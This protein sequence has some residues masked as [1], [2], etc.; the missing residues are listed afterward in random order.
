MFKRTFFL[1]LCLFVSFGFDPLNAQG[2]VPVAIGSIPGTFSVDLSGNSTYSVPIKIPPGAAGTAPKISLVYDSGSLGGALGAGWSISGLSVITRGPKDVFTDG[3]SSGIKLD[4]GDAFYLDGQRLIPISVTG[5][6][7]GRKIEYRK[8]FD[9]QTRITQVG[10]D[11]GHCYFKVETKGGVI[12]LF[13]GER[14]SRVLLGNGSTL[15]LAESAVIDTA[16]SRIVTDATGNQTVEVGGNYIEFYYA[17]NGKGNYDIESIKYTGRGRLVGGQIKA[18]AGFEPFA[19]IDFKYEAVRAL[20][21]Y[22]AGSE[23]VRDVRLIE[24][25][26][27]I[28]GRV[29]PPA[30]R[31]TLEYENRNTSNRF[32]LKALHQF[33]SDGQELQP[34]NFEYT[35][36]PTG[37]VD[38]AYPFPNSVV[39]AGRNRLGA[40]YRF[41]HFAPTG[42][43]PDLLFA[44]QIEG[45]LEAFA[46]RNDLDA[47]LPGN[48]VW[49]PMPDF[50]PPVAFTNADGADLGVIVEDVRGKGQASLLQGYQKTGEPA[51]FATYTAGAKAF[52]KDDPYQLP[53]VVSLDGKI[54]AQYRFAK[55]SGGAA[56]DLIYESMGT[57]GFL[58]NTGSGW[59]P[60]PAHLPPV[61]LDSRTLVIDIDCSGHPALL[62]AVKNGGT[63]DWKIYRYRA[64]KWEEE[65]ALKFKPRF[66]AATDPAAIRQITFDTGAGACPGLIVASA[67]GAGARG[68]YVTSSNGWV[69]LDGQGGRVDKSPPFNLVDAVGNDLGAVVADV[70]GDGLQDVIAHAQLP[71]GSEVQFAY[72][73]STV[74][75]VASPGFNPP[76]LSTLKVDA[77]RV[78]AFIGN[79]DGSSGDD[80]ISVN[81]TASVTPNQQNIFGN[82]F[83]SDGSKFN[84]EA[85]YAPPVQFSRKDK[86]DRGVRIL[87]LHGRNL[88]DIIY[89]R[90]VTQDGKTVAVAGASRNTGAGWVDEPGLVPLSP[91][92]SDDIASNPAQFAD[93]S[94]SGFADMIYSYRDKNNKLD[95]H[96]YRNVALNDEQRKWS[97]VAPGG[98]EALTIPPTCRATDDGRIWPIAT[99]QIGDMG[100]RF[101]KL[102]DQRLAMLVS[103]LGP[104]PA[105]GLGKRANVKKCTTDAAGVEQCNGWD[106][107]R[108]QAAAYIFDGVRWTPAPAYAPPVPFVAQIDSNTEKSQ[109][110][111]VQI[112]DIDQDGLPDIVARFKHPHD[113]SVEVEE[114]WINTGSGWKLDPSIKVPYGLDAPRREQKTLVQWA[115]VNGDGIPD[116]VLSKR[117]GGTN[118]SSTWLG[119]GRGWEASPSGSWQIP[120]DAISDKDGDPGFRLVDT[121]GDGFLDILYARQNDDLS[122]TTGIFFN[123][124]TDWKTKLA[125][126]V[127]PKFS[128]VDKDGL[129]LGVRIMSVTGRGLSDIV[130]SFAGEAPKVR[131][132]TSRRAEMLK[133]IREGAGLLTAIYYRSLSENDDPATSYVE[134]ADT[135]YRMPKNL[136]GP[137]VYIRGAPDPF[138]LIAPVPT[139]YVVRRATV[140]EGAGRTASFSYRYGNY[141]VDNASMRS[142]G[143]GWR[144]S[145]NEVNGV[146]S[147]SE[148]LQDPRFRNSARRE[149]SCWLPLDKWSAHPEKTPDDLCPM[150]GP[151]LQAREWE[152]KLSETRNCW[153][154]VE[155]DT[156]HGASKSIRNCWDQA[157]TPP[158]PM[159]AGSPYRIRQLNLDSVRTTQFELDRK[160]ISESLDTFVYDSPS[161]VLLRRM[162]VLKT[163]SELTDGS[164]VETTNEYRQDTVDDNRWY[165]GRLTD[166][167]VKKVG[168]PVAAGAPA[169]KTEERASAFA[170]VEATGLL[171]QQIANAGTSK[172]ISTAYRRDAF[173]NAIETTIVADGELPRTTKSIYDDRGRFAISATNALGQS[174][175]KVIDER[176]GL[177]RS[178]T[179]ANGLST[180]YEYDGF[181]RL[182]RQ[183]NP[184]TIAATTRL[185]SVDE[186]RTSIPGVDVTAGLNAAFVSVAQVD[187]LPPTITVFDNKSRPL[188]IVAD[189]FTKDGVGHRYIFRDT[190]YDLL[191]R[192]IKTSLP[193]ESGQTPLWSR[194]FLDVM[195]RTYRTVSPDNLVTLTEYRSLQNRVAN[196]VPHVPPQSCVDLAAG[197]LLGGGEVD[198][199][200]DPGGLARKSYSCVNMRK[201]VLLSVDGKKGSVRF[202][203]DAGGRL[204]KMVGPTGATTVHMYDD[205]G[206]RIQSSDPDLG[207][208]RYE[209]NSFGQLVRQIDAKN[210]IAIIEYDVLGRVVR[211]QENDSST[212][213]RFDRAEHGI[214]KTAEVEKSN[215]Y[216]EVY[217]YDGFGRSKSV[218]VQ[219]GKEQFVTSMDYDRLGRPSTLYYPTAFSVR[220]RYDKKGFLVGL[221]DTRG[222]KNFWTAKEIDKYGRVTEETYGNGVVTTRAFNERNGR[223][224]EMETVTENDRRILNLNLRYD[225]IGNLERR[226]ESVEGKRETFKYDALDRLVEMDSGGERSRYAF[227]AAGRLTYKQGVGTYH[228]AQNPGEIDGNTAKPF[229]AVLQTSNSEGHHR[230]FYD[231][232]GNMTGGPQGH[233][234]YTSDNRAALIYTEQDDWTRFDYGPAGD[235]FRQFVRKGAR[236][237]ET[238]YLG[239]FERVIEYTSGVTDEK[240]GRLTRNRHYLSNSSGVFAVVERDAQYADSVLDRHASRRIPRTIGESLHEQTWYLHA[241]QLGSVLRITD[242]KQRLRDRIWYDPWGARTSRIAG[243][244]GEGVQLGKS[245][246]RGFTGH[247]HLDELSL[248]HM[249]GRMYSTLLSTFTSVDP[250]NQAAADTQAGNG[251]MY[252]RGNP[253]KFVD[254]SGYGFLGDVWHA[255]TAPF[256]AAGN[257]ISDAAHGIGHFFSEA[258][259]WLSEN[260]RVVVVVIVVIVIE[261]VTF[262]AATAAVG[263]LAGAI[264]TGMAAGAAGGALGAALYGGTLDDVLAAAVK[265]AVIGG[266]SAG[267]T[268][269]VG[270]YFQA[271]QGANEALTT[272]QEIESIAAHGVVGGAKQAA[273]GGNFWQGFVAT[274]ATKASSLWGPDFQSMSANVARAAVVGGTVAAINGDKFA[275]GAILGSFSYVFN[276]YAHTYATYGVA[277]GG[278]MAAGGSLVVDAATGGVNVLAT[279]AEI[280]AGSSLG[281]AVGYGLGSIVDW[282]MSSGSGPTL[283]EFDFN[284]PTRPPVGP[285]GQQWEWKGSGSVGSPQGAWVPPGGGESLH[286]DLNHAPPIGP[287]WDYRNKNLPP[288]CQDFR[289]Y[290]GGRTEPK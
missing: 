57:S 208:W 172:K 52:D 221:E 201:Q 14:G 94:G 227:D 48:R 59:Q 95:C 99:N 262:G 79:I 188:R 279:P 228:Y 245:W 38:A 93:V 51:T 61:D 171:S 18:D 27:G 251:Y 163:R 282:A 258:G 87:D 179:D 170:Y 68:A 261:V 62:S 218:A 129:D 217:S 263:P 165:L 75:W 277:A 267:V 3:L 274:A 184:D 138:P 183:T 83:V 81:D 114:V 118:S 17:G 10:A 116:I 196:G 285:G 259:K 176:N 22:I 191:G 98:A 92:A 8:A 90:D 152:Q 15:L 28:I 289:C 226:T 121:K 128:F 32:V 181:G 12:L 39:L 124:G 197:P 56:P 145:L 283:P 139:T 140:D 232:N 71:D 158:Q 189:G 111:F 252:A 222:H 4:D 260:W 2:P 164:S 146:L 275:N 240:F 185:L 67:T 107:S 43:L 63:Y 284:D 216:R 54:V 131:L 155:G 206:N 89:R 112:T 266:I 26:N 153:L 220:N 86:Q 173:G 264:L 241:D 239:K 244:G 72:L 290:P 247:E 147:R 148:L 194:S 193:Y 166:S 47:L 270:S 187:S 168:D 123:N 11:F 5:A 109:D 1:L 256:R 237:T 273:E 207:V 167:T 105:N 214:G 125:D 104:N 7:A 85:A 24:V 108:L 174:V 230:F 204:E 213:W 110:L 257:A 60:D 58:T 276:D 265:G 6:G 236:S 255:V 65:P 36:P 235:R 268:Y 156:S 219:I 278:M 254:P 192:S 202:E 212:I 178:A 286:P 46:F 248:I 84:T 49:T 25:S 205:F 151:E 149:A 120:L 225:L 113:D 253:L 211:R 91:L 101:V 97:E 134:D 175:S 133:A 198:V 160:L 80:V 195:G 142:L 150:D 16:A 287:H 143:F 78:V 209:Y 243:D 199:T 169:R 229:H 190:E 249:N 250:I 130:Q 182:R 19:S 269:G 281:G 45:K 272:S 137:R 159:V 136:L 106:W 103:F 144:E 13:N 288:G 50:K 135:S 234:E 132:N 74:G 53:F 100:V 82:I 55:F 69:P 31:Y 242:E 180:Q 102:N 157:P 203:Y 271:V 9:D 41:K 177:P 117:S 70:D 231:L 96:L 162:N 233:F 246:K 73:Q 161:D 215:G 126:D 40:G 88:P 44:A 115:D 29:G 66:S 200:V 127:V 33:G 186:A 64:T 76:L 154:T 77:P 280:A 21:N 30:N 35:K 122:L 20:S 223:I 37:W 34:T 23:I 210:Q 224:E 119:T 42:K 141:R 238:L